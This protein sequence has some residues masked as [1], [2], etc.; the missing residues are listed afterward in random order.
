MPLSFAETNISRSPFWALLKIDY[1]KKGYPYA[2]LS[3]GGPRFVIFPHW[4]WRGIMTTGEMF[5]FFGWG[6]RHTD[7]PGRE[8]QVTFARYGSDLEWVLSWTQLAD[9]GKWGFM[10]KN[11]FSGG[12]QLECVAPRNLASQVEVEGIWRALLKGWRPP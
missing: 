3:T 2:N 10:A 4:F 9:I 6:L 1:R 5:S 8:G 12:P 7:C 11:H